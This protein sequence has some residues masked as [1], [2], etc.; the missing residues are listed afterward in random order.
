MRNVPFERFAFTFAVLV[1]TFASKQFVLSDEARPVRPPLEE[2]TISAVAAKS[3][4]RGYRLE[5]QVNIFPTPPA[6]RFFASTNAAPAS[7][8]VSAS[9]SKTPAAPRPAETPP[10]AEPPS[11]SAAAY[12]VR[13][14]DAPEPLVAF[15]TRRQWPAASL[16]KLMT[17]LVA[18]DTFAPDVPITIPEDT[19]VEPDTVSGIRAGERFAARDLIRV[20]LTASSNAAAEA[21]ARAAGRDA[22]IA[23]LNDTAVMLGLAETRIDDP[24]GLSVLTQTTAADLDR[25]LIYLARS[26][27]G[28][29]AY[30]RESPVRIRELATGAERVFSSIHPFA[31]TPRFLGGKTGQTPEARGNLVSLFAVKGRELMV[32][33]LG[34]EDRA[35]DTKRL[36][37]FAA[38]Q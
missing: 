21:L 12:L 34:S 9:V 38:G 23:A 29:L 5:P 27:P 32:V 3:E 6:A 33:V 1:S 24:A 35:G 16:V 28:I 7:S 2:M 14:L 31:G 22:F 4:P 8:L 25:F 11:V 15:E 18:E 19:G 17:A 20:M 10:R 36:Y 37:E 30:T 26:R 13:F